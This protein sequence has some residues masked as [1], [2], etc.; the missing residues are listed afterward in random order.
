MGTRES[1]AVDP[2][3]VAAVAVV[4]GGGKI[5]VARFCREHGL[6]RDTFY[7]LVHRFGVEGAGG[8]SPRSSA[9]HRR[10][11]ALGPQVAEAVLRAR[12]ELT[13]Q[14]W[15]NGP[16]SILWRLERDGVTPV[17]SR[18]SIYRILVDRGQIVPAPK[19]RPKVSGTRFEFPD[20]NACWQID[21]MD[22]QL[23]DGTGVCILQIIDDHSRLDV[24]TFAARSENQDDTWTALRRA[25]TTYGLPAHLL[26]DNAK[27][28]SGKCRGYLAEVERH[29]AKLGVSTIASSPNHPKTCGK[30]ERVHQTL[31]RW[32]AARPT[33]ATLA[34]LQQ[35]LDEFRT[36]YNQRRHQGLNGHTPQHRYHARA[37][38]TIPDQQT[39]PAG[40]TQRRVSATGVIA[41]SGHSI[42]IGRRWAR[43]TA[44]LYWQ[45]DRLAIMINNELV[46]RLT[47]NRAVR[48]QHLTN[49]KLSETS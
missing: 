38:A 31:Q 17:P 45:T 32:L 1:F 36:G 26:S 11:T 7:R 2:D 42:I 39:S 20:P 34:Q 6:S 23:A 8:F 30:N 21:G 29:L 47:L 16:I 40:S 46:G 24:G 28:F 12:K 10:P 41:F 14:G 5:N 49:P 9:P 33:P 13:E 44:T 4:A 3:V 15:D 37:K 27:A 25:I 22:H 35:L 18:A 19:K 43:H 48:Y